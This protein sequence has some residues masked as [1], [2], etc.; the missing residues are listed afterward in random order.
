MM[1][2][3]T[4][5]R[6]QLTNNI[7]SNHFPVKFSYENGDV[8]VGEW[9]DDGHPRTEHGTRHGMGT[10]TWAASGN[11][12]VGEWVDNTRHGM[13]TFTHAS[14]DVYDGAFVNG[15]QNGMGRYTWASGNVYDGAFVNGERTGMGIQT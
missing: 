13:G 6:S 14:G 5:T 15:E 7:S 9:N 11:V 8:Y 2:I 1:L 3:K 10:Y 4:Q 12:Y